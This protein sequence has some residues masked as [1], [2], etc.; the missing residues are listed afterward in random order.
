MSRK[1]KPRKSYLDRLKAWGVFLGGLGGLVAACVA[2][3]QAIGR[4]LG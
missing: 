3:L 4:V 1:P 2:A